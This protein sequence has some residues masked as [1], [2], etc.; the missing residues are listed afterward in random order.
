MESKKFYSKI[1]KDQNFEPKY[2]NGAFGSFNLQGELLINFFVDYISLP[3]SSEIEIETDK[4]S[5]IQE[6]FKESGEIVRKIQSSIL[7]NS[8]TAKNIYEWLG[9]KIKEIDQNKITNK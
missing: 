4:S 1:E 9:Q 5:S 6:K 7:L 3:E 2:I 8:I